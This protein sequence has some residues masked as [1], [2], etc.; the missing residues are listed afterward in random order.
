VRRRFMASAS[1]D[2]H[3]GAGLVEL[4]GDLAR[5]QGVAGPN[6]PD[7]PVAEQRKAAHLRPHRLLDHACLQVDA[8]IAQG[9]TI[10]DLLNEIQT[11]TGSLPA[12][13]RDQ[14]WT[15]RFDKSVARSQGEDTV[16][17]AKVQ[18]L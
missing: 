5:C 8:S 11:D 16:K 1:R 17:L 13:E 6:H 7:Q 3:M 18:R 2:D 14:L 12:D 9:R 10:L 4:R 15:K